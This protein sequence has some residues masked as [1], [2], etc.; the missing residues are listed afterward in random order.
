MNDLFATI[1]ENGPFGF[2]SASDFSSEVYN[3]YL[4]QK[5]GLVLLVSVILFLFLYYKGM[6]KPRFSSLGYWCV[7][8]GITAIVNFFYLYVDS[9]VILESMG[10][11]YNE[12][13]SSLATTNAIYAVV[14]FIL[15]AVGFKFISTNNS[16]IPF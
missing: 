12:E 8:L 14:L 7:I 9:K 6:D 4:Y 2:Y 10:Y 3:L 13:F 5:Y 16:K 15:L 1:Y 11:D